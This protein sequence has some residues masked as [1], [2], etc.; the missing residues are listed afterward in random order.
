[1]VNSTRASVIKMLINILSF[2]QG[3]LYRAP[4]LLRMASSPL[5]GTQKSDVYSFG[6]ILYAIHS[7]QGPFGLMSYSCE[8]ILRRVM[9]CQPPI[10]PFR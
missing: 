8:D 3:L 6:I 7:R 4:E 5:A 2:S 10:P 9:S 1:M